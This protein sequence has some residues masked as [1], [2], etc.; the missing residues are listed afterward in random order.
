MALTRQDWRELKGVGPRLRLVRQHL[1]PSAAYIRSIYPRVPT[2][3]LPLAY[4]ARV[5]RGAPKW[6][7]PRA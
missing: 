5:F 6:F 7:A 2:V 4:A 1:F 3:L